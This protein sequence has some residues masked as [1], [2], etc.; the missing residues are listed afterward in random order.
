MT[1]PKDRLRPSGQNERGDSGSPASEASWESARST[2]WIW[3]LLVA[4]LAGLA[5][6]WA[7][8]FAVR[9]W[10]G[11]R[12][13]ATARRGS[14]PPASAAETRSAPRPS[15]PV[16]AETAKTSVPPPD[17]EA[18]AHLPD[19]ASPLPPSQAAMA[20]EVRNMAEYL[21]E[22]FPSDP[23][24]VEVL[25]RCEKWLGNTAEAVAHWDRCLELNPEYGYA[26]YGK[27][28]VSAEKGDHRQA[29]DLFRKALQVKPD[30][31]KAQL[32]LARTLINAGRAREAIAVLEK[33]V[34]RKPFLSEAYVLLGQACVQCD[35]LQKAKNA[36]EAA[37][38]ILPDYA[39]GYYGLA[40]ACARL[41]QHQEAREAMK[42]FQ[43]RNAVDF[44]VRRTGKIE[45][46][47]L[48]AMRIDSSPMYQAAG[49]VF[50]ARKR[51]AEAE[52]L[53][54][55]AAAL[56]PNSVECRQAL[57]WLYRSTGRLP[58]AIET[59]EQ[60]AGIE[61]D[62]RIYLEEIARLY[63]ELQQPGKAAEVRR[64]MAESKG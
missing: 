47:D 15:R 32:E 19:P 5:G 7:P 14:T 3:L 21:V 26:L 16:S 17:A 36:Y 18:I 28:T 6:F 23:D 63:T 58:Q 44:Q 49:Q 55:R 37:V 46:D 56:D 33:H 48:D 50:Y 57:A 51:L 34:R 40:T 52:R 22:C 35:E 41:G 30:W 9:F 2:F 10:D 8:R 12:L 31:P 53:W 42:H 62:N 45:Y 13:P 25:A 29:G 38:K 27:A 24:S 43:Q 11:T 39:P 1:P 64:R 61:P 54:R 4:V 59:L 20:E 60:L